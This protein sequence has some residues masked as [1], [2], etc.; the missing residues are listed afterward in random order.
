[1]IEWGKAQELYEGHGGSAKEQSCVLIAQ[2][3]LRIKENAAKLKLAIKVPSR[4][5]GGGRG[6]A[7]GG[8]GCADR[9]DE[10]MG[11]R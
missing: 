9:G 4:S 10:E 1:M 3:V 11:Y 6:R 7:A 8:K 2:K 5:H